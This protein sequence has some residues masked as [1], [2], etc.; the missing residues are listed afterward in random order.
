MAG[1]IDID[2]IRKLSVEQRLKLMEAIWDTLADEEV[3][4]SDATLREMK[5]RSEWAKANPDKLI[6][7]EEMTAR[8]RSLAK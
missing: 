1:I 4:V 2:A 7:H 3:P 8:L 5:R 6:S